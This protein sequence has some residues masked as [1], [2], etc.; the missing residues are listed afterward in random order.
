MSSIDPQL[1]H[2]L[3]PILAGILIL[4]FPKLLNYT[5]ALYFIGS[6]LLATAKWNQIPAIEA[7]I[8]LIAGILI[9]IAPKLLNYVVAFTLISLGVL[10]LIN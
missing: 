2:A 10:A 8:P 9:L 7:L 3:F 6:G 5:V 1:L 4:A